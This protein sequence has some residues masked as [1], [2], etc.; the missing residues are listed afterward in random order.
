MI[1]RILAIVFAVVVSLLAVP[2]Q[3]PPTPGNPEHATPPPGWMCSPNGP[4]D[5]KCE[6]RRVNGHADPE[7]GDAGMP[8]KCAIQEDPKCKVFCHM[9]HCACPVEDLCC[10]ETK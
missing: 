8:E 3:W 9:D 6:C 4:A 7:E 5:H 1:V 10:G 2:Q